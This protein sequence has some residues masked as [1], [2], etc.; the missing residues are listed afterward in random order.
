MLRASG[1]AVMQ[2][3]QMWEG[4]D[5]AAAWRFHGTQF[6]RIVHQSHMRPAP[7]IIGQVGRHDLL[8]LPFVEHQKVIQTLAPQRADEPFHIRILPRRPGCN[9]H[10]L[11]VQGAQAV[12]HFLT[13]NTITV[14]KEILRRC[15]EREASRSCCATHAAVGCAVTWTWTTRRRSWHKITN[16]YNSRNVTVGTTQKSIA[17]TEPTWLCRKVFQVCEGGRR[18]RGKYFATV[19]TATL[20][21]SSRS[22]AAI[23]GA[24][25]SRFSRASRG[26][27]ARTS[28]G[29]RGR[30]GGPPRDFQRQ[31]QRKPCD[32]TE[33]LFPAA[34]APAT[35]ASRQTN[36]TARPTSTDPTN[37]SVGAAWSAARPSTG[38]GEPD[39]RRS[40]RLDRSG[41]RV[42]AAS[43]QTATA[44]FIPRPGTHGRSPCR[45]ASG[46]RPVFRLLI[47]TSA[48]CC[49]LI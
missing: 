45:S 28:R 13:V 46:A 5:T 38:D 39:S 14:S 37:G 25:H 2:A 48:W 32:A 20:C 10:F 30:P 11:H 34:P 6:R 21:P 3:A 29:S 9:D 15:L 40:R 22:S 35:N 12:P 43:N 36:C 8:Q 24:P 47:D 44:W 18:P 1:V 16:T 31:N 26:S 19:E 23:R 42:T 33:G 27:K 17:A 4:H 41:R 7:V 49:H